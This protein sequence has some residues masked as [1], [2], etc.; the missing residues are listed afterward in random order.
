MLY[1]WFFFYTFSRAG[2]VH[3]LGTEA[4]HTCIALCILQLVRLAGVMSSRQCC[5]WWVDP[6]SVLCVCLL[7]VQPCIII[8]LPRWHR[9]KGRVE[10]LVQQ[11]SNGII[12]AVQ[13]GSVAHAEMGGKW[14][15]TGKVKGQWSMGGVQMEGVG[16]SPGLQTD[17]WMGGRRSLKGWQAEESQH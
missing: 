13:Q 3:T 17:S 8:T 14:T 9:C 11:A 4:C 12:K 16:S 1:S 2:T 10:G 15:G 6:V 5:S 7:H